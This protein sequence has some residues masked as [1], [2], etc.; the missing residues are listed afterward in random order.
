MKKTIAQQLNIK[1]FPFEIKND[2]GNIIYSE[3]SHGFWSKWEYD[4]KG[5]PIYC[6]TSTGYWSKWEYDA[7]KNSIYS[8]YSTGY[9]IKREY[10]TKG[11]QT[12]YEDSDGKIKDNRPKVTLTLDEVAAKFGIS[13]DKLQIKK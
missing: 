6:E 12:Y 4:A 2:K 10:D 13:V 5:N 1:D 7:K 11:N 8:E 9:W 3:Y